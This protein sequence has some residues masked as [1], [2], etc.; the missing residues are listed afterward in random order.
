MSFLQ[1]LMLLGLPL[2]ALPIIIHLINQRRFQT[3]NWAA[4]QFLL[5]ANRISQGYAKI[6]RWLILAAR[7]L[8][9]AALIFAISRPLSSGFFGLFGDGQIGTAIVL[10]DRSPSMTMRDAQGVSKLDSGIDKISLTLETLQPSRS[11][12]IDSVSLQPIEFDSSEQLRRIPQSGPSSRSADLPAM[13]QAVH[14]YIATNRPSRCD[15][16]ICSDLQQHDWHADSGRWESVRQSFSELPQPVQF[17]LIS[18]TARQ[19]QNHSIRVRQ[20]DRIDTPDGADLLLSLEIHQ[21]A[22]SRSTKS[23]EPEAAFPI[24]LDLNGARSQLS[25]PGLDAD[26]KVISQLIPIDAAQGRGWGRVS[27]APDSLAADDE[28]FFVYDRPIQRKTV[29]VAEP[30]SS[31]EPLEFAASV[32]SETGIV[33]SHQTITPQQWLNQELDEIALVIWQSAIP[34]EIDP[35]H[36]L[37]RSF[38]DRGGQAV[39][40]PPATPTGNSFAGLHWTGW[41]QH[42]GASVTNWVSDQGLLG[43]TLEGVPLPLGELSVSTSCGVAGD[44]VTLANIQEDVPLLVR[45]MNPGRNVYFLGTTVAERDSSLAENGVVLYAMIHRALAAGVANLGAAG[46]RI[47]GEIAA[48]RSQIWQQLAGDSTVLSTEYPNHAGVYNLDSRLVAIN[49]SPGEDQSAVLTDQQVAKLFAGLD[50][51]SVEVQS[52]DRSSLVQE[53]WRLCLILML[54]GLIVEAVLCIPR[55]QPIGSRRSDGP[56]RTG[57]SF[58]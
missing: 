40:L 10:L 3:V 19:T 6:R 46:M 1:P 56:S 48:E 4:M 21:A 9:I 53:I 24:Q 35:A 5:A 15:V 45:A 27:I 41:R 47:A 22:P 44:F 52:G 11:L 30:E 58:A 36:A 12:L 20:A 34:S 38:S 50:F 49:R 25:V 7:T 14:Q 16:W 43:R 31:T 55:G 39:F 32:S 17:H 13:L 23:A 26:S 18:H 33:C 51:E 2:I 42:P 28:F 29:I 57:T 37:L 54:V 8:A